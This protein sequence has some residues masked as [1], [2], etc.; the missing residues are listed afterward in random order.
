MQK[1]AFTLEKSIRLTRIMQQVVEIP[2]FIM[3]MPKAELHLHIEGTLEAE[4]LLSLA[5]S[6]SI[7]LPYQTVSEVKAVQDYGQMPEALDNFLRY[8]TICKQVLC[9]RQDFFELTYNFLRR[10]KKENILYVEMQFDPQSHIHRGVKF[11]DLLGGL[12]DARSQG[13]KD[14]G[15]SSNIIM[16]FQREL[17]ASDAMEILGA[18]LPY[19]R[20]IKGVGLDNFEP[21]DFPLKFKS[22]FEKARAEGYRVTT[23]CDCD[24]PYSVKHIRDSID[25]L[26]VERID[27]G[28]NVLEDQS[29]VDEVIKHNI[30]LTVCPTW[31][32]S[33][34]R[35]RRLTRLRQ[36]FEAGILVS[37][38]TDDPA[39][40]ASGYLS[41]TLAAVQEHSGYSNQEMIKLMKNAFLSA[42]IPD[43]TKERY[44]SELDNFE[45][46]YVTV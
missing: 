44:L 7:R 26:K 30:A 33:H 46:N 14:F 4:M 10:C 38:N 41:R 2:D 42:W 9:T 11:D 17:E 27:H 43:N 6:N 16:C 1:Y 18:S 22:V 34:S 19:K 32:I 23:H 25:L 35:P 40:F 3:L 29:L 13:Q 24:Q 20:E 45:Q 21:L 15:V 39:L 36:L 37:V 5:R 8:L 31:F 28:I 12:L